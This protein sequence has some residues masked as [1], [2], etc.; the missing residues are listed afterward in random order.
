MQIVNDVFQ[1]EFFI[2]NDL[3]LKETL[4]TF[5]SIFLRGIITKK[6][7]KHIEDKI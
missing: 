7:L 2:K 3:G 1:P 4:L 6:G 5:R